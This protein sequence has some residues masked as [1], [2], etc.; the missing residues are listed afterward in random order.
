MREVCGVSEIASYS[1]R[2]EVPGR[3]YTH[4]LIYAFKGQYE[5]YFEGKNFPTIIKS[6]I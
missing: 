4:K 5:K 2:F 3:Y 1:T 6:K